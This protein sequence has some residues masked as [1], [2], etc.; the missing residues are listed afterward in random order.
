MNENI[1]NS[2]ALD[3]LGG[4]P[5]THCLNCG[6][7]LSGKYCHCCGQEAVSKTP[8]V[9]GFVLEY[10][11]NAFIWDSK[12][13]PTLWSLIRR[14][15]HLT[16]EYLAGKFNSQEHPL[17]LNMF[18]LFVFVTLFLFFA[19]DDKMTSS[20]D[21]LMNDY[22]VVS[23]M[24]VDKL[25]GDSEYI[26]KMEESPRDTV[27]LE[28]PLYFATDYPKIF[29]NVETKEEAVGEALDRWVAALPRVL[30][31]DKI[32]VVGESG[33][34][35]FNEELA[36]ADDDIGGNIQ[37]ISAVWAEMVRIS[38]TY[39]PMLLLLTVP[40]LSFSLRLVQNRSKRPGIH[41]FIFALHYT[42]VLEF[43]MI[44][45]YVLHLTNVAQMPIL[46][47]IALMLPCVY[48]AIA[49]HRV[50]DTSWIMAVVKSL[51]TSFIYFSILVLIMIAVFFV[52]CF[53]IVVNMS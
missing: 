47:F 23:G 31:D 12:F 17:K 1:Q 2:E 14:P 7:E 27:L 53:T 30:I 43:L 9:G 21:N 3:E 49:Y 19:S 39:L 4:L 29:T 50:Y 24:Q 34:Y 52:A 37:I 42:A 11:N 44:C 20:L 45:I 6:T 15:G 25:A 51:L 16:N 46:E 18:L 33:Y 10:L 26:K 48:L 22:R 32:V 41:H 38:S 36:A 28:A 8:T 5:Y 40:F 13:L 35:R